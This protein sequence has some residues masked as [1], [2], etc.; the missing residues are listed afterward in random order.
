LI[1][2]VSQ[3]PLSVGFDLILSDLSETVE[4]LQTE[5]TVTRQL[6]N[7]LKTTVDKA[8]KN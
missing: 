5:A 8:L 7:I 2:A 1:I 3:H 6:Q 4:L